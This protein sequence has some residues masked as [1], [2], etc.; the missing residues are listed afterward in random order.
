MLTS[1]LFLIFALALILLSAE[2]FTNGIEWLG[3]KLNM[4]SGAVGSILAAIGTALPETIIPILAIFFA[5]DKTVGD[6]IS[7]GA[8]LGAPLMLSTIALGVVGI[9]IFVFHKTGRRDTAFAQID[10][11]H[12]RRDLLFFLMAFS[13]SASASFLPAMPFRWIAVIF[14]AGIYAVYIYQVLQHP[15]EGVED[16]APLYMSRRKTDVHS[17]AMIITQV[18]IALVVM[19]LGADLFVHQVEYLA[20][21]LSIPA[22]ILS[23]IITPLATELPEKFNSVIWL[24]ANK[25][26][27]ALGNITGA[28]VFQSSV[29]PIVGILLTDWRFG[30][31]E[32]VSV[33][34]TFFSA[35]FV[36]LALG[37]KDKLPYGVFAAG[38]LFYLA[39]LAYVI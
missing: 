6:E 12:M 4:T 31:V 5:H 18:V 21:E 2:L 14:L 38:V 23:L 27:L 28:M 9:S 29:I 10:N 20:K 33:A 15:G 19:V 37:K 34:L 32:M 22:L 39:F 25:D 36:L 26:T 30:R 1:I 17:M 16:M 13:V 11:A 8:I 7:T 35:L 24:K 3:S